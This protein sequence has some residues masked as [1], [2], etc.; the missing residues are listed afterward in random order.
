M[1]C[2]IRKE[3]MSVHSGAFRSF[4]LL[5]KPPEFKIELGIHIYRFFKGKVELNY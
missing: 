3:Q 5:D 1:C 2:N 4:A